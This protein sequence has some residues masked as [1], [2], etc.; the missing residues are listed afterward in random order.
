MAEKL[1]CLQ[2]SDFYIFV[3]AVFG[4]TQPILRQFVILLTKSF[5]LGWQESPE[6]YQRVEAAAGH[7]Q[8]FEQGTEGQSST[9]GCW[10]ENESG[11]W[12]SEDAAEKSTGWYSLNVDANSDSG[13]LTPHLCLT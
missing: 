9:H 10:E 6:R 4:K 2:L 3:T 1:L 13:K 7:V 5:Y 11:I 12:G 8:G